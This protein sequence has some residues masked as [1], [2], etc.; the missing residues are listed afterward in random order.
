[1]GNVER[2]EKNTV[3]F[4]FSVSPEEFEKA[5]FRSLIRRMLRRLTC[6]DSEKVGSQ[7]SY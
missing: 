2:T 6:R 3:T 5:V 1:M 4:E 7:S